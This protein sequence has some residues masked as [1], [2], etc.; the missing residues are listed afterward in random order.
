MVRPGCMQM[1]RRLNAAIFSMLI[2]E[3]KKGNIKNTV[4]RGG[5]PVSDT[6]TT[7][8]SRVRLTQLNTDTNDNCKQDNGQM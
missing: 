7:Q 6:G 2:T 5:N 3:L 8:R 4:S 1:K